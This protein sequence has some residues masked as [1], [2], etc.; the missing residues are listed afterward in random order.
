M[1]MESVG[2]HNEKAQWA[3]IFFSFAVSGALA[4]VPLMTKV[5]NQLE[6]SSVMFGAP[7]WMI[8]RLRLAGDVDLNTYTDLSMRAGLSR[9]TA[10]MLQAG[11]S[12]KGGLKSKYSKRIGQ[13]PYNWPWETQHHFCHTCWGSHKLVQGQIQEKGMW[14]DPTPR[15]GSKNLSPC[16]NTVISVSSWRS[17]QEKGKLWWMTILKPCSAGRNYRQDI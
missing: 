14:S 1:F 16:F 3:W 2:Q 17:G 4:G 7:S 5:W 9:S 12:W 8:W 10:I 13:K 15:W 11:M 6:A